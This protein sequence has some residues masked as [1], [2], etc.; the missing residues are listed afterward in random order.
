[1]NSR[2]LCSSGNRKAHPFTEA[3]SAEGFN[4]PWCHWKGYMGRDAAWHAQP[5]DCKAIMAAEAG[6]H[7]Q[8]CCKNCYCTVQAALHCYS[9]PHGA[10]LLQR[11]VKIHPVEIYIHFVDM[12]VTTEGKAQMATWPRAGQMF[13]V[14][15]RKHLH[16]LNS[17]NST[18]S[19]CFCVDFILLQPTDYD[20]FLN[21]KIKFDACSHAGV[22]A[23]ILG[24][25]SFL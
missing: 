10:A 15:L 23:I 25:L 1:M 8:D 16:H 3:C 2:Q 7:W 20:C 13:I 22:F 17:A 11:D 6:V 14:L 21:M 5:G 19:K 4:L 18:L 12:W 24:F 9:T